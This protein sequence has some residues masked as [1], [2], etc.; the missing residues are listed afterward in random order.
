MTEFET[1]ALALLERIAK[2]VEGK[3]AASR[4]SGGAPAGAVFPPYGQKKGEPVA[5]ATV[6]DLRYYAAGCQ[7]SL[8][9]P[10][11]QRWHDK[12]RALLDA[13]AAEL[14]KHGESIEDGDFGPPP[15]D[16]RG[17]PQTDED[18]PF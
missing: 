1:K 9:D 10:S 7:R 18:I 13:I 2:A 14:A 6:R 5:G 17:P 16:R 12:E 3:P 8:N 15:P 4:P 11:K